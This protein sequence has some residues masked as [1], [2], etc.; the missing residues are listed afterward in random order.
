MKHICLIFSLS[1]LLFAAACDGK[2]GKNEVQENQ[3]VKSFE[4]DIVTA[5]SQSYFTMETD[6]PAIIAE[7]KDG[8]LWLTFHKD[9]I[10]PVGIVDEDSY[11]LPD[12]PI[13]VEGLKGAPKNFIIA[14]IGQDYN[15]ILCVVTEEGKAQMLSL[16]NTVSTGDVEAIEVPMEGIVGFKAGPGGPWEDEDG[17][18]NYDYTTIFGMDAKGG[19]HEVYVYTSYN[20]L[21]HD[22]YGDNPNKPTGLYT[23]NLSC[24]W[25]IGLVVEKFREKTVVEKQGR[26]WPIEEDW[27]AMTFRYGFEL[28]RLIDATYPAENADVSEISEKGM[29]ELRQGD[30]PSTYFVTSIEG[31]DL[32]GE[33]LNHATSFSVRMGY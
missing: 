21:K 18:I 26:F 27:D 12:W 5:V 20:V 22:V 25:K 31:P 15:P 11:R 4:A 7:I 6:Q 16:W 1:L 19:E 17:D 24:D 10:L 8:G 30:D 9:Q 3:P 29:F 14:D 28:T 13:Q 23:L 33:G 2:S 32:T